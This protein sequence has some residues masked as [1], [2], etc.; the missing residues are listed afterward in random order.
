M[1]RRRSW[2]AAIAAA[3]AAL[4]MGAA[5]LT[6]SAA[7]AADSVF[8]VDPDTSAARWVAANPNDSKTA[9]IRDRIAAVPQGRWFTTT[10]TSAVRSQVS[11]YVGAAASQGKIPIMVVY[12]IPNRDC[13]GASTGGAPNHSAYRAWIDEVAAGLQGRAAYII[14][15]PDVLPIMTSRMNSSQQSDVQ[16]PRWLT[17]ARSSSRDRRRPRSTSTSATR[18]G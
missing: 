1:L 18:R 16:A 15:E 17:P 7:N 13:S 3:V 4:G 6:T 5:M 9:V 12:N 8:Y 14:L 10:N 2:T 11:S